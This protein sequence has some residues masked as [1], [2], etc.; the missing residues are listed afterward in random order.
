MTKNEGEQFNLSCVADGIPRPNIAW[1][2][3]GV[4]IDAG[5][6]LRLSI[7]TSLTVPAFRSDI[8]GHR[9]YQW[10]VYSVLTITGLNAELDNGLYGCLANNIPGRGQTRQETPYTLSVNRG[11]SC[12]W[13]A[14]NLL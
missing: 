10:G 2:R 11:K 8:I 6:Q 3:G 13:Y 12:T 5:L 4:I 14:T 9:G 1:S 7:S